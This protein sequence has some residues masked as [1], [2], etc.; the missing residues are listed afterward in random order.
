M[1]DEQ[2]QIS[3]IPIVV[4]RIMDRK[5]NRNMDSPL[6]ATPPEY[7]KPIDDDDLK[8]E[9][10]I[11]FKKELAHDLRGKVKSIIEPNIINNL[12]ANLRSQRTWRK[13]GNFLE[14]VSKIILSLSAVPAFLSSVFQDQA[15]AFSTTSGILTTVGS[16]FFLLAS[17][18]QKESKERAIIASR[19]LR[20]GAGI[21]YDIVDISE[22]A[23]DNNNEKK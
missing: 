5:I 12:R 2:E 7:L 18:S 13:C 20:D 23:D 22:P 4:E 19:L 16:M 1:S 14:I 15:V 11:I 6:S 10:T 21:K 8:S 9:N 17:K 3:N